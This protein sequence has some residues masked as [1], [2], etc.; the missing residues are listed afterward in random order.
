MLK[1]VVN[2][3]SL[4]RVDSFSPVEKTVNYL[5]AEFLFSDEWDDLDK[6]AI[7]KAMGKEEEYDTHIVGNS[8]LIPWEVIDE[9]GSFDICLKGTGDDVVITTSVV[10]VDIGGTLVGGA[11]SNPPSETELQWMRRAISEMEDSVG[12]MEDKIGDTCLFVT[13]SDDMTTAS[14][15]AS[16]IYDHVQSG[17]SAVLILMGAIRLNYVGYEPEFGGVLFSVSLAISGSGVML[18]AL[19]SEDKAVVVYEASLVTSD[20]LSELIPS[21]LPNPKPLTINGTSYDGS[22]SVNIAIPS[23]KDGADG[24]DGK[25]GIN[26]EDGADGKTP[27][28]GENGNWWIGEED[29]GVKASAVGGGGG[30][31]FAEQVDDITLEEAGLTEITLELDLQA[32][33]EARIYITVP[34]TGLDSNYNYYLTG[35]DGTYQ[36]RLC[37]LSTFMNNKSGSLIRYRAITDTLGEIDYAT[38]LGAADITKMDAYGGQGNLQYS[39]APRIIHKGAKLVSGDAEKLTFPVGT[40]IMS[41]AWKK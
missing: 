29:T 40:R 10:T 6:K 26:G 16:E 39:K 5:T 7:C 1:F 14:H 21:K 30:Y 41:F 23:G 8:C 28:I 35:A 37:D 24:E 31:S 18:T 19:V 9:D 38:G 36:N 13:V 3:Q 4:N 22:V 2:G 25:D 12:A 27:Y 33:Y 34:T 32:C 11:E 20:S 15:S 17:G